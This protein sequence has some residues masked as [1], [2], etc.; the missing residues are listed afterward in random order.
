LG[1]LR[2]WTL[3]HLQRHEPGEQSRLARAVPVPAGT[4]SKFINGGNLPHQYRE[5]LAEAV[6]VF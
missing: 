6:A 4:L 2:E 1:A 5:P 3:A